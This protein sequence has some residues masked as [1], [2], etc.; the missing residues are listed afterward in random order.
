VGT[1]LA[2][3]PGSGAHADVK[4]CGAV[5]TRTTDIPANCDTV[6][7][8]HAHVRAFVL[9]TF[10]DLKFDANDLTLECFETVDGDPMA[11]TEVV[12]ENASLICN[13]RVGW[14]QRM[15][16]ELDDAT[17]DTVW[18]QQFQ[19]LVR[20]PDKNANTLNIMLCGRWGASKSSFI[21][22]IGSTFSAAPELSTPFAHTAST[23][24]HGTTQ[25]P[26]IYFIE[27][28][29]VRLI[30]TW[31]YTESNDA[32][33][34]SMLEKTITGKLEARVPAPLPHIDDWRRNAA[35]RARTANRSATTQRQPS[36]QCMQRLCAL[37]AWGTWRM[38]VPKSGPRRASDSV[39]FVCCRNSFH[40]AL[41]CLHNHGSDQARP[42]RPST[43][44]CAEGLLSFQGRSGGPDKAG[45]AAVR[46]FRCQTVFSGG[47]ALQVRGNS[48]SSS[49]QRGRAI[50]CLHKKSARCETVR[51]RSACSRRLR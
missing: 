31:G 12:R 7:A 6:D 30:D 36:L 29:N 8:L 21:N 2:S 14:I 42:G 23:Q 17:I 5:E 47:S 49:P 26:N 10:P 38:T 3:R 4:I 33:Y 18:F 19:Q 39:R 15:P 13:V 43:G 27:E 9:H 34:F 1:A 22:L 45:H 40:V 44:S 51:G 20:R 25:G 48:R 16:V 46:L 32:F 11:S 50:R 35:R 24:G 41:R 28:I 37:S